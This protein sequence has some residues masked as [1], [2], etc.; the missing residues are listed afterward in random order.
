MEDGVT[1]AQP[2]FRP[3]T[4][5][6]EQKPSPS[7]TNRLAKTALFLGLLGSALSGTVLWPI[8]GFVSILAIVFGVTAL[9]QIHRSRGRQKGRGMAIAGTVLGSLAVVIILVAFVVTAGK[10]APLVQNGSFESPGVLSG[11]NI[12]QSIPGW[13]AT[14]SCYF[15]LNNSPLGGPAADGNQ[16]AELNANCV[17]GIAQTVDTTPGS[18]YDLSFAFG[19]R[20]GTSGSQNQMEVLFNGAPVAMLGP[21]TASGSQINWA[22]HHVFVTARGPKSTLTFRGTDPNSADAVGSELDK[23]SLRPAG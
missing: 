17:G 1:G 12:V 20:P 9:R 14:N 16:W 19:A 21:L 13:G 22:V 7:G 23:V 6:A 8:F 18:R 3:P 5:Q 4:P 10:P 11:S 2:A 15:R